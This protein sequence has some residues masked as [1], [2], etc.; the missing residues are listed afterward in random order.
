V[1]LPYPFVPSQNVH[2]SLEEFDPM[3]GVKLA[4]G[5]LGHEIFKL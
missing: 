3:V 5:L 4:A 1:Y 2:M